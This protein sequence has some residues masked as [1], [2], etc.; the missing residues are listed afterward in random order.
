MKPL[1]CIVTPPA[2]ATR[3]KADSL[4][5]VINEADIPGRKR[6]ERGEMDA[7]GRLL[8]I[9]EIRQLK[10]RHFRCLDTKGWVGLTAVF[11]PDGVLDN[12]SAGMDHAVTGAQ[13]IADAIERPVAPAITVNH[14]HMSEN[15]E[16]ASHPRASNL[17]NG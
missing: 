12:R 6:G 16:P 7:I 10:A 17:S 3:S 11:A 2:S 15:S 13:A 5:N 4:R 1:G 14:G 9:E 8:A